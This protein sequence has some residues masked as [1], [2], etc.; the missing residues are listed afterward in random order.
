MPGDA[1]TVTTRRDTLR[2]RFPGWGLVPSVGR[3]STALQID[4]VRVTNFLWV[5]GE[6]IITYYT[7]Y[8]VDVDFAD[9]KRQ[10]GVVRMPAAVQFATPESSGRAARTLPTPAPASNVLKYRW[11]GRNSCWT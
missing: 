11:L 6:L 1:Q 5:D 7:R 2:A 3:R 4:A 9:D 10:G 8:A